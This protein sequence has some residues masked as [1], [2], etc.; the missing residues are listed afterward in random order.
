[1]LLVAG[2]ETTV[3]LIASGTL[4]LLEHPEQSAMLEVDPVLI[5]PAVE[6][7]L[8]YASPVEIATERCAREDVEVSGVKI[9]RGEL[10]FGSQSIP[11]IFE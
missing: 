10:R 9:P 1:M 6:K 5:K 2:H 3:N 8:R 11:V 4:A 7:L